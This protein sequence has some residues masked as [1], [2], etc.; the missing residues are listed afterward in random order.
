[1]DAKFLISKIN[2]ALTNKV[3]FTSYRKPHSNT[4]NFVAQQDD[5]LNY[6]NNFSD[7]GFVFAPF[8]DTQKSIFFHL[9]QCHFETFQID[10]ANFEKE[11]SFENKI[12][13]KEKINH[14]NLVEKGISFIKKDKT[15][16]IVL[17]RK[18]TFAKDD[19]NVITTF[20]KLLQNYQTAFVYIWFHPKVGL[21]LGATPETL[22]Q[23]KGSNFKTMSLAGTQEYKG[24]EDVTWQQKELDEQDVVTNYILN[25]LESLN[26]NCEKSNIYTTKAGSLLHLRVDITGRFL[27]NKKLGITIKALHPTPAICGFPTKQAKEF[28]LK[29]ENYQRE[30]YTGYLG[31]L[32][33][34]NTRS[35]N[36]R[37]IENQA[38]QF[39]NQTSDLF[40]NLRCMQVE[41]NKINLYLGGGITK[42]SQP[43]KEFLETVAKSKIIKKCL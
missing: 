43:E 5:K 33:F 15:S 6:L 40:V 10:D 41:K 1:M 13:E 36:R 28:I 2:N 16:K 7:I 20:F 29:H 30:F 9:K 17:S 18:E 19:F 14:L 39:R 22:L 11:I 35:R 3:P 37:N 42:D 25:K 32:N 31:E 34:E 12:S 21:W 23:V 24:T 26:I 27:T 38:Y 4:I 8:D